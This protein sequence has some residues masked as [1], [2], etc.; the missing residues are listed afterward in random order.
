MLLTETRVIS[1]H[2][3]SQWIVSFL[4]FGLLVIPN[5]VNA[6]SSDNPVFEHP[7]SKKNE[8]KFLEKV[9]SLVLK[10]D[11]FRSF[12]QEKKIAA[13]QHPLVSDGQVV[14]SSRG[15]CLATV[16]PFQSAIKVTKEGIWQKIGKQKAILKSAKDNV[17]IK[18]TAR[19][20][21]A[22]FTAKKETL[23]KQFYLYYLATQDGFH[24]GLR[25]KDRILSKIISQIVIAGTDEIR[26]IHIEETNGDQTTIKIS[27]L[28]PL[29]KLSFDNCIE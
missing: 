17:Q 9:R 27:N 26:K 16:T 14:L 11:V 19:I 24:I 1:R 7:V 4:F 2:C 3:S 23:E 5:W 6:Q 28:A 10:K 21:I 25:P 12:V 20:M 15:V 13:L 8:T 22:L 29:K 18:H